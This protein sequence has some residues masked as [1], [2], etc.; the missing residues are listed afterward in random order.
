[1]ASKRTTSVDSSSSISLESAVTTLNSWRNWYNPLRGFTFARCVEL[2]EMMRRGEFAE[3]QWVFDYIEGTHPVLSA[4]A[5]RR[6]AAVKELDWEIKI[7][8]PDSWPSGASQQMADDQAGRLRE[9]YSQIDNIKASVEAL[10]MAQFRGFAFLIPEGDPSKPEHLGALDQWNLVRDGLRGKWFW[11]PEARNV[12]AK[13][14]DRSE[15]LDESQF[16]IRTAPRP[17]DV[18]AL[19]LFVRSALGEK[20]WASWLEIYGIPGRTIIAPPNVRPDDMPKFRA[21]AASI[22]KG[23]NGSLPFGSVVNENSHPTGGAPFSEFIKYQTEMMVLAGTGGKLTMLAESGSGNLAGGAHSDTFRQIA[24]ASAGASSEAFQRGIDKPLLR[25]E[26]PGR[27][28][29]AYWELCAN[30]ETETGEVVK[31]VV[32]LNSAGYKVA[33]AQVEEKTGYQIE[34]SEDPNAPDKDADPA[35]DPNA[36]P[37]P[38]VNRSL[39]HARKAAALAGDKASLKLL[40]NVSEQ[41][42]AAN[43][44][45]LRPLAERLAEIEKLPDAEQPAAIESLQAD[46]ANPDSA[47]AKALDDVSGPAEVLADG[48]AA[49]LGNGLAIAAPVTRLPISNSLTHFGGKETKR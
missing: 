6:V 37:L 5:E 14:F 41:F 39:G 40:Q 45:A 12:N 13:F 11:N 36:P 2:I 4:I 49:A 24:K 10:E 46:L 20:N 32:A 18:I 17:I 44:D 34:S 35:V 23:Q 15:A 25:R 28:I 1:M 33:T 19:P 27:P 48:M 9:V 47:L 29:L 21:A 38:I 42:R 31:D 22:A 26:F 3:P 16:I 8:E 43:A 7:T 30:E